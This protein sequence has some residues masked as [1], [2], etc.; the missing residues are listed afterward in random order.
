M[1]ANRAG[2]TAEPAIVIFGAAVRADG[3]PSTVLRRRVEAAA[4]FGAC[5]TAPLYVPTGAIGRFGPSEASIMA[6]MLRGLGVPGS[7]ILPEETGT[8]TFSSARAVAALLQARGHRGPVYAATSRYH[9][10]RSVLLLRLAGLPARPAP[11]PPGPASRR[12]ARRWFWRLRE[13]P[14][15]PWDA[16]LMLLARRGWF[17]GPPS[18]PP[19]SAPGI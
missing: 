8:D 19:P 6:R 10:P 9:L 14:A 15:L 3:T 1:N 18:R 7:R 2:P 16:A 11:P 17:S 5:F 12:F 4:R 13:I